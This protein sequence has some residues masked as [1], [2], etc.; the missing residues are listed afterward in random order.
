MA[1]AEILWSTGDGPQKEKGTM[2]QL[3][4]SSFPDFVEQHPLGLQE[5]EGKKMEKKK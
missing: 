3:E 4:E 5:A 2:E 1:T